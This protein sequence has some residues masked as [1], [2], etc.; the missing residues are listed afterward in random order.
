MEGHATVDI[1]SLQYVLYFSDIILQS[2]LVPVVLQVRNSSLPNVPVRTV[3]VQK[4]SA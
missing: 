1:S 4:K 3:V 2:I